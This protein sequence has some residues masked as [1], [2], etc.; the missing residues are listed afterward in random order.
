MSDK[1]EYITLVELAELDLHFQEFYLKTL[2]KIFEDD[3]AM[4]LVLKSVDAL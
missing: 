3:P 2:K 4:Y 1:G